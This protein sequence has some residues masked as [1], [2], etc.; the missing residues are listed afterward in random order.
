MDKKKTIIYVIGGVAAVFIGGLIAM[1]N[2][3]LYGEVT[4]PSET[5]A[6]E[7]K[8]PLDVAVPTVVINEVA[9]VTIDSQLLDAARKYRLESINSMTGK[10][11][12]K[13]SDTEF[14]GGRAP[15]LMSPNAEAGIPPN[16][17]GKNVSVTESLRVSMIVD[18]QVAWLENGGE[19][20][21][22][23]IGQVAFGKKV[24]RITNSEVCFVKSGCIQL[25]M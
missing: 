1:V 24:S 7:H 9:H 18:G 10:L 3:G 11:K 13:P 15:S 5:N 6:V 4:P 2:G 8:A 17:M 14:T 21:Q 12:E 19:S 22:V 23:R 25:A 20:Q 16:P